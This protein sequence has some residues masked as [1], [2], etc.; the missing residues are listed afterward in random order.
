MSLMDTLYDRLDVCQKELWRDRYPYHIYVYARDSYS[1]NDLE[2]YSQYL[3][4]WNRT[5]VIVAYDA[6]AADVLNKISNKKIEFEPGN[7]PKEF[8]P[9]LPNHL[10]KPVD[11]KSNFKR[12][13]VF[14]PV[15]NRDFQRWR[16]LK[17]RGGDFVIF[18][19]LERIEL[20][21]P[22]ML[23]LGEKREPFKS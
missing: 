22:I 19:N 20:A 4:H 21:K 3:G 16:E 12:K 23:D 9:P 14:Y 7:E 1:F 5:G 6:G 17:G 13:E 8:L 11:I 18:S 10:D 15:R 2:N